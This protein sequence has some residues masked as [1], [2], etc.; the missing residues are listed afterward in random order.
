MRKG[1][2]L[3]AYGLD[4][5][6]DARDDSG[7]SRIL[8]GGVLLSRTFSTALVRM[9]EAGDACAQNDK[10]GGSTEPKE[11]P[12]STHHWMCTVKKETISKVQEEI[13][14]ILI[15]KGTCG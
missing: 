12:G 5:R 10:R 8:K 14:D 7:G 15:L 6:K 4:G 1:E 2:R 3:Y 13:P 9:H 11:P